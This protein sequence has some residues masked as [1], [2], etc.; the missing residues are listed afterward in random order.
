M[1]LQH[2]GEI[3]DCP[4]I[5]DAGVIDYPSAEHREVRLSRDW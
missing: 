3:L 5:Q 2:P 1:L 4:V